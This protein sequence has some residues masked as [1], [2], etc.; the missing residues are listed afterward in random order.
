[1]KMN[2]IFQKNQKNSIVTLLQISL[3]SR[4]IEDSWIL[5]C[6]HLVDNC[7]LVE[8]CKENSTQIYSWKTE[9]YFN[10]LF[11]Q[12]WIFFF[13]TSPNSPYMQSFLKGYFVILKFFSLTS[14]I[15]RAMQ[16]KTTMRY[17]LTPVR[18]G[19]SRKST[20]YKC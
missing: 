14:L 7:A 5:I 4:L 2:Y 17:H 20:N 11:K 18:M 10:C 15:I 9:E 8:I 16:I 1:M 12:F 19:I 3:M 13:N 6:F